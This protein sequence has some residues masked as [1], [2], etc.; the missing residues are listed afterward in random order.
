MK[1]AI[2]SF[3]GQD[4]EAVKGFRTAV[5]LHGHT[6]RSEE[7]L[8]FLPRHLHCVPGV[9]QIVRLYERGRNAIDFARA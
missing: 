2:V 9:S 6:L 1:N 4:P 5:C 7:C 8:S 3:F